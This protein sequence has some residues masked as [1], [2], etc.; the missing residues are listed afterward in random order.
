MRAGFHRVDAGVEALEV[1]VAELLGVRLLHAR[2]EEAPERETATD[3]V[4]P[5]TALRLVDPERARLADR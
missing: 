3:E 2:I 1:D 4:L 5:E